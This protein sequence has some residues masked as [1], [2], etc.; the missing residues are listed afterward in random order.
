MECRLWHIIL[1]FEMLAFTNKRS[2]GFILKQLSNVKKNPLEIQEG[3]FP[4]AVTE[5][6]S[7]STCA[8]ESMGQGKEEWDSERKLLEQGC[9]HVG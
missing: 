4:V 7:V 8:V 2:C 3:S 1:Q 9:W 5:G 6:K